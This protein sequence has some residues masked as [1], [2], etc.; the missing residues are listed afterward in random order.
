MSNITLKQYAPK[1]QAIWRGQLTARQFIQEDIG[2][3]MGQIHSVMV[4]MLRE[5]LEALE[6]ELVDREKRRRDDED[7]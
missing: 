2:A 6:R 3:D 7:Q 4:G 1:L 5:L